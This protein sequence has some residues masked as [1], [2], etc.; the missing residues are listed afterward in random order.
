MNFYSAYLR[1]LFWKPQD[2]IVAMYWWCTG[3][4]VRA[5]NRLRMVVTQ[6]L[7]AYQMWIDTTERKR[8]EAADAKA[9]MA[10]WHLRPR[11]SVI[12][13]RSAVANS[14]DVTRLL[15]LLDAQ[16]YPDWEL[17]VVPVQD[18]GP[19]SDWG[20]DRVVTVAQCTLDTAEA[21]ALGIEQASGA[22]ILP[23]P[24]DTVLPARALFRYVEALQSAP[25]AS[26]LYGDHDQID[27]RGHRSVPWF[28]PRWNAEMFLAQ[29]Y[30]SAACIIRTDAARRALPIAPELA[31]AASYALL[32]GVTAQDH[33]QILHVP[34]VQSHTRRVLGP[35]NQAAR[36]AAVTAHLAK[37]G[38]A[39]T[40]GPFGT[41]AVAW[42]LPD[43][44]PLVSIIVP[45]RDHAKLLCACLTSL[46]N[47]TAYHPY[48][49]LIVD[50]GSVEPETL[51]YLARMAH[52]PR[53]RVL[54]YDRPYNYSA[55]NNFAA[56]HATGAYLCLLNNDTEVLDGGW[57][58]EL[59]RQ[60][61]RPEVGAAGAKLLYG[62][63]TIQ[64]AG[65]VVGLGEAA[66][67]AH[68][69]QR[70]DDPG[71]F[72]QAHVTHYA[73]AVTAACLVVSRAKFDAVGGL[74]EVGLQIAFN[75][76]DLCLRLEQAGWRNVYV[77]QAVLVH[78]ESKSR[79]KDFARAH[80]ER[81][82]RELAVL[83]ER[84][85]TRA[86]SDPLH[87]PQLDRSSESYTLRL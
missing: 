51:T 84:W 85:G 67:H 57:L 80:I 68:R 8:D 64:H 31:K 48:E 6:S 58:T 43:D 24:G 56:A 19:V 60:A 13:H 12:L 11:I 44:L 81:Y 33:A 7:F 74:D 42:P 26:V 45:T 72:A 20:G 73:S 61:V 49:V 55:I 75:D 4:K 27:A 79:G 65:V 78:H 37:R 52:D 41:L 69:F 5:R 71:Y 21:L 10:D 32:L 53:V 47:A 39:V 17:I 76:V 63:G 22:Y 54:P 14:D 38:A 15:A 23:L 66:G 83:Q 36:L 62:D 35:H 30:L 1:T 77:P 82:R 59:M 46:L 18:G 87:H 9:A 70:G 25:D 40:A 2:A 16:T 3:R 34:H 86:Y 29:D 50:N 28:K